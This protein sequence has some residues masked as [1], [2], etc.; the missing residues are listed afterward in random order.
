MLRSTRL[1]VTQEKV[2]QVPLLDAWDLGTI[3]DRKLQLP[4][5]RQGGSH[6]H[7]D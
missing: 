5:Y 1:D 3:A 4:T 2:K 7:Q 6:P